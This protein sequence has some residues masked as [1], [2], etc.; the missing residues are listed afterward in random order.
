MYFWFIFLSYFITF[1]LIGM[2]AF[3]SYKKLQSGDV[4]KTHANIR[5]IVQKTKILPSTNIKIGIKEFI[6]CTTIILE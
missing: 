5:K 6:K 2:L 3:L 1:L 4:Y